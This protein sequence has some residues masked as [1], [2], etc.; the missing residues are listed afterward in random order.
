MKKSFNTTAGFT[1]VEI[2]VVIGILATI[3]GLTI[4]NLSG[5]QRRAYLNTQLTTTIAD[6]K[7][8]QLK[9][10]T[11]DTEGRS[12]HD[13]YGI[14]FGSSSYTLFHGLTYNASDSS[15]FTINLDGN[16]DLTNITLPQSEIIFTSGS[17]ELTN[18][19][20]GADA[21]T[22]RNTL[23]GDQKTVTINRYGVIISIN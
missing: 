16:I 8:Q 23:N 19:I 11:G 12:T 7:S 18:Y 14:H 1:F 22:L 4:M 20:Q 21:F 10:M 2:I 17:G 3:A 13:A 9:A 15:N 6:L 5:V